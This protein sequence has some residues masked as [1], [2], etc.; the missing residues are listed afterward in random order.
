MSTK[1]HRIRSTRRIKEKILLKEWMRTK[2]VFK[3]DEDIENY[4][5][6]Y[7]NMEML[8]CCG[9]S[10]A[11]TSTIVGGSEHITYGWNNVNVFYKPDNRSKMEKHI[12]KNVTGICRPGELLAIMGPSGAGKTTLLNVLTHRSDRRLRVTGDLFVN[13]YR[14]DHDTL[15]SRSAY[16][17]QDDLFVGSLTVR[18]Q[19]VFQAL[20]RMD[21][22]LTQRQRMIRVEEVILELGLLKCANSKIGVP[23]KDKGISGGEMKRLAFGCEVLTGPS[24]LLCDEPTSGL[25]SYMA[26]N[27]V[28]FMKNMAERGKTIISTIHQPSSEVYALFDRVLLMAEGQVAFIGDVDGAYQFFSRIELPCPQNYNPSDYYINALSIEPGRELECLDRISHVCTEFSRKEEL[29][30]LAA[31]LENQERATSDYSSLENLSDTSPYKSSGW[32]QLQAVF[33]RSW[34]EVVREPTLIKVRFLQLMALALLLGLIYFQT[35]PTTQGIFNIN[36]ALFL[37]LTNMTFQNTAA[38]INTFCSQRPLFLREHFN[39]MYRTDIYYV[40]K[41]LV[42]LP[43][44]VFYSVIYTIVVYFMIGL[45]PGFWHFGMFCLVSILVTMCSVSFGYLIS[46]LANDVNLALT[47]YGPLVLPLMIFGGFFM[48]NKTTPIYLRW[49]QYMSWFS[50][51][52]EAL[53]IIQWRDLTSS[54]CP[55]NSTSICFR[56]GEAVLQYLSYD[57]SHLTLNL[58]NLFILALAYRAVAYLFLLLRTIRRRT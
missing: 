39:G 20:L 32:K 54:S 1:H 22:S 23:G 3:V 48:N 41:N 5:Q 13:G 44:F 19:L 10:E 52:N 43:F 51:G 14:T 45:F 58:V 50:Y 53:M 34:L 57:A 26:Q 16:V 8:S 2:G 6:Q 38:V 4:Q 46:C 9:T 29:E 30:I 56:D 31:V 18:E 42:E 21:R 7:S 49:I 15:T 24:L 37:L 55:P 36:G 17:Q 47:L 12:L 35:P 27:V 25:D 33:W 40:A 28:S 11:S